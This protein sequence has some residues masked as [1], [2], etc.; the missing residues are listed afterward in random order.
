[1]K[2]RDWYYIESRLLAPCGAALEAHERMTR[3]G[4]SEMAAEL[5]KATQVFTDA[6]RAIRHAQDVRALTHPY[7]G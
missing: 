3:A 5:M 7:D 1:M 2:T 6:C 4:E